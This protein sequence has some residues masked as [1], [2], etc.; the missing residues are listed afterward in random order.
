MDQ[1]T[2]VI[3]GCMDRRLNGFFDELRDNVA[4]E[5]PGEK[6]YIVRDAGGGVDAVEKTL[7]ELNA[8]E[9]HDYTHTNCGAMRVAMGACSKISSGEKLDD[10]ESSSDVYDTNIKPF[11]GKTYESALSIEQ[12]NAEI[13]D[14]ILKHLKMTHPELKFT[15]NLIDTEKLAIPIVEGD[16]TVVVGMAYDG[17]Y[18]EMA[19]KYNLDLAQIYFVQAN[20]LEEIRPSVKLAVEKLNIHNVMFVSNHES[21]NDTIE[22]WSNDPSLKRLF[23]AHLMHVPLKVERPGN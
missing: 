14:N 6:I 18:S 16:F 7:Y 17:K 3:I 8:T 23:E 22:E 1:M 2:I 4:V 19:N 10:V 20:H 5:N 13:Q 15:C 11:L 21:E 9:I 12:K